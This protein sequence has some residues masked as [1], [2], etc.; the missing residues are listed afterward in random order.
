MDAIAKECIVLFYHIKREN[1]GLMYSI[2][3]R[4]KSADVL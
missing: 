2:I 3:F 1:E 4:A